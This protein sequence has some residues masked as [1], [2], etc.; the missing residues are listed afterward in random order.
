MARTL[1]VLVLLH[2]CSGVTSQATLTQ[3]ASQSISLGQTAKLLCSQSDGGSWYNCP[4]CSSR[5]EGIPDRFSTSK[6]GNVGFLSITNIQPEDEADYYCA[7]WE[8]SS[9]RCH[10]DAVLWGSETKTLLPLLPCGVDSQATVIQHASS[11]SGSP[12]QTVTLSCSRSSGGSWDDYF[13]WYQQRPGQAPRFLH[14]RAC[15]RGEGIPD[16][17]TGS[18]SGTTGSLTITNLQPE[19]ETDYYC[20]DWYGTGSKFHSDTL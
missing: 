18:Y 19:D 5:G 15:S 17:F 2:Y 12:G 10:S 8:S 1:F 13:P 7:V 20:A 11:Q 3:P 14:C 9:N 16:R 4:D 6:S